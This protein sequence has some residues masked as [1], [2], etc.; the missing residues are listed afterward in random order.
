LIGCV[1]R[2]T[3]KPPLEYQRRRAAQPGDIAIVGG[4]NLGRRASQ[5]QLSG[6]F[7]NDQ[8]KGRRSQSAVRLQANVRMALILRGQDSARKRI[9]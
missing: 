3:N 4:K 6:L 9:L 1:G 2:I 8:T 5:R 7:S